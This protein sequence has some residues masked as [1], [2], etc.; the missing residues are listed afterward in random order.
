ML[1]WTLMIF[2][3]G[4]ILSIVVTFGRLKCCINDCLCHWCQHS[5]VFVKT[6]RVADKEWGHVDYVLMMMSSA[7][8]GTFYIVSWWSR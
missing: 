7:V 2:L 4:S 6:G 1:A 8:K 5:I 3:E